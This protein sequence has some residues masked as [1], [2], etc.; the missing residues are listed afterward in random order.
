MGQ[1]ICTFRLSDGLPVMFVGVA[2]DLTVIS[3]CN[4][5]PGQHF[6]YFLHFILRAYAP[7]VPLSRLSEPNSFNKGLSHYKQELASAG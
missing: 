1:Q 7:A 5:S 3:G 4:P 2:D 6:M